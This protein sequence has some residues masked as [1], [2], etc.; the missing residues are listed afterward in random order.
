MAICIKCYQDYP[1]VRR[2]AGY[3]L[4]ITCGD[5]AAA[6]DLENKH[7]RIGVAW[8]KG[9]EMYLGSPEQTRKILK[10]EGSRKHLPLDQPVS[11][12]TPTSTT[13][14]T[15]TAENRE[16]SR[17]PVVPSNKRP[18][19]PQPQPKQY[20]FSHWVWPV[21]KLGNRYKRAVLVLVLKPKQ[22]E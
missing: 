9:P 14:T 5:L 12:P 10:T 1:D 3:P 13:S 19:K 21:D 16:L 17:Q 18:S 15:S 11:Q 2:L 20:R 4:C 22:K 7:K 6:L 8:N